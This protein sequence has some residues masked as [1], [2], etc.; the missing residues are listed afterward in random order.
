M[1]IRRSL[2]VVGIAAACISAPVSQARAQLTFGVGGGA[3]FPTGN[4]GNSYATGYNI[5]AALGIGNASWPVDLRV[6]GMF[7]QMQ[8]QAGV[9]IGALQLWT[10]NANVVYNIMHGH[11]ITP[12]LIGGVGYYNTSYHVTATDSTVFAGGNTRN[13][14]F[15]LNGGAGLRFGKGS[16]SLF[17][18]ARFHYVYVPGGHLEFIPL[19]AGITL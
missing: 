4:L 19:T 8:G 13:N 5:L 9:P 17:L 15:G 3:T 14:D 7:N 10:L 11:S 2:I 18:E 12:Y 6:D 1:T 16:L